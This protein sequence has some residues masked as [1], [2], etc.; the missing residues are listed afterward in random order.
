M[1]SSLNVYKKSDL[2]S[3]QA[4]AHVKKSSQHSPP[5]QHVEAVKADGV[6]EG[7]TLEHRSLN[8]INGL[9]TSTEN[10]KMRRRLSLRNVNRC[11]GSC[12]DCREQ[13]QSLEKNVESY[14]T[15][16]LLTR[17]RLAPKTKI[18]KCDAR[19]INMGS[20]PGVSC[21]H[22]THGEASSLWF[23]TTG[24]HLTVMPRGNINT[25]HNV[26][27]KYCINV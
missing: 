25:T 3:L 10:R 14:E 23:G 1:C 20:V 22:T 19:R 8:S 2:L 13:L 12:G 7:Q 15:T 5:A 27:F 16:F 9:Q 4:V 24:K 21:C 11:S 18:N 6:C 26:V 17:S